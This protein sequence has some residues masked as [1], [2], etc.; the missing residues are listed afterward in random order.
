MIDLGQITGLINAVPG[1]SD[2]QKEF[3]KRYVSARYD[4]I[5]RPAYEILPALEQ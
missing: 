4:L 2:L 1:I 5:I 3:Y